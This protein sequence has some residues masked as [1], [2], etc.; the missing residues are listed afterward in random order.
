MTQATQVLSHRQAAAAIKDEW[1]RGVEPDARAALAH[2]PE[3][4]ADKSVVLELAYE[5][6]CLRCERGQALDAEAFCDRFPTYCQ[7]LRRLVAAH[8]FLGEKVHV[9]TET[10]PVR[11]PEP[12]EQLG[13]FLLLRELGRGAFARVYLATE[14]STGGRP[15]AVKLSPEGA[16]EARTLG[17]LAHPNIV[18][19][20]S[21]RYEEGAGLTAVVMPFLGAA[22]LTDV[23]DQAYPDAKAPPPRTAKVIRQAT[24]AAG[25]PD[26]PAPLGLARETPDNGLYTDAVVRLAAQ[27]ADAL[28]LLHGESICHRDLKPSN[29]LVSPAGQALLLDFNLSADARF[30]APRLGGT[31]PYMAPEQ[32][33]ALI[34]PGAPDVL[35]ERVDLFALGVIL[36]QLLTGKQPYGA[37][38]EVQSTVEAASALL[39]RQRTGRVPLRKL[40]PAVDRRLALAVERCLAFDPADRPTSAAALAADFRKYLAP[41]ARLRRAAARRPW[42]VA[43]AAVLLLLAVGGV[44]RQLATPIQANGH[45]ESATGTV[46]AADAYRQGREA[47][48]AGDYARAEEL[49]AQA[50]TASPEKPK[51]RK[52]YMAHVAAALQQADAAGNASNADF[53]VVFADLD[54]AREQQADGATMALQGYCNSWIKMHGVAVT[55]YDK[56][57]QKGFTSAALLNDRGVS[58][59]Q[60]GKLQEAQ[61]D[62]DAA[63]AID[64][65]L[66]P[67]LFNRADLFLRQRPTVHPPPVSESALADIGRALEM[68]P[69]S[70]ELYHA[71][72]VL[73]ADAARD[74]SPGDPKAN[75]RQALLCVRQAVA[76]GMDPDQIRNDPII[77]AALQADP[78]FKTALAAPALSVG[79]VFAHRLVNPAPYVPD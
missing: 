33:S 75:V 38:P 47:F 60:A 24:R 37:P 16:A 70:Q 23:L 57:I 79:P 44:V 19:V 71:A 66:Q 54:Q 43:L 9:L 18:P 40:N 46:S 45:D 48:L 36:Y 6:Y 14:E 65:N 51:P 29:V 42:A 67:A 61:A 13:D 53:S 28:A 41:P 3:L 72:A 68:G 50:L 25:R 59:M 1:G 17:R 76:C 7:S 15:V 77:S 11:W 58:Y 63:L 55:W 69:G 22:T 74:G 8:Q 32:L 62:F 56:A 10:R 34:H 49:F 27:M 30:A 5:E 2:Q 21:A 4:A 39:D 73:F 52:Y 64:P 78:E 31:L 26:D 35:D 20:L 12:G